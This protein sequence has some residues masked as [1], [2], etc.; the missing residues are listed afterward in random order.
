MRSIPKSVLL[1]LVLLVS[2]GLAT[3]PVHAKGKQST[4]TGTVSDA[5]CGA[6]HIPGQEP[7]ACTRAC[8]K[9]GSMYALVVGSKV[10][11]LKGGDATELDKLAGEKA[12]V[13]GTLSGD[14]IEVASVAAAK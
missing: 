2:A 4:Y 13:K 3:L 12:S 1:A 9:Q 7:A 11:K 6:H 5:M 8:V 14:T 10:Y